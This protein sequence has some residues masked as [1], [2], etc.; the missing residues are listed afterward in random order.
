MH[1]CWG[2]G[3]TTV[4]EVGENGSRVQSSLN[5]GNFE[6]QRKDVYSIL[7][8]IHNIK[9]YSHFGYHFHSEIDS[10]FLNEKL[11]RM[12]SYQNFFG[13]IFSWFKSNIITCYRILASIRL[14]RV[15][16]NLLRITEFWLFSKPIGNGKSLFFQGFLIFYLR[17][18]DTGTYY[19]F[20][21]PLNV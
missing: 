1:S 2:I 19:C 9:Q 12:S 21:N 6:A 5:H 11:F 16:Y 3:W 10:L 15:A 7:I 18:I 4:R 13:K 17:Y 20:L 8:T 14:Q